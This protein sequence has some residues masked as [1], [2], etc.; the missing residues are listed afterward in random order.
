MT[1]HLTH[2]RYEPKGVITLYFL[3]NEVATTTEAAIP[4]KPAITTEAATTT[5]A[6]TTIESEEETTTEGNVQ[7]RNIVLH[8]NM[9]D[10]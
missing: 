10:Y 6:A 5:V 3:V 9:L 2:I 1:Q 4:P 8:L 7:N